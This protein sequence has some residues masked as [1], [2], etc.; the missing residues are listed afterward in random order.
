M[1]ERQGQPLM[2]NFELFRWIGYMQVILSRLRYKL[3]AGFS[4]KRGVDGQVEQQLQLD[5]G[6]SAK[7][8]AE[9][10]ASCAI[11]IAWTF[12]SLHSNATKPRPGTSGGCF[13]HRPKENGRCSLFHTMTNTGCA[14]DLV[15]SIF[16]LD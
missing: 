4:A 1:G 16:Q 14:E 15:G 12:D 10:L 8:V 11:A 5:I 13:V 2:V 7:E 3:T 9:S 6:T